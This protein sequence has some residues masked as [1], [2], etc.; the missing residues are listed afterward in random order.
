[1]RLKNGGL[2]AVAI[3]R[4]LMSNHT[5]LEHIQ[6]QYGTV[7]PSEVIQSSKK[8]ELL[9]GVE[10]EPTLLFACPGCRLPSVHGGSVGL[11]ASTIEEQRLNYWTIQA[12]MSDVTTPKLRFIE[13]E[14][15]LRC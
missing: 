14:V 1:M 7:I 12:F 11:P 2:E 10:I 6:E 9:P 15:V 3:S 5:R 4:W 13:P 8:E